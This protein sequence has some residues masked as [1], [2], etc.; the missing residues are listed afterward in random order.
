M[1]D[2]T[3]S[4][5]DKNVSMPDRIV[6]RTMHPG[7]APIVCELITRV[8]HACVAPSFT[9]EG[10]AAFLQYVGAHLLLARPPQGHVV[11]I[12]EDRGIIVGAV[13]MRD[14][15]HISLFFVDEAR[16]GEGIGRAL[17]ADAVERCRRVRPD[18]REIS[19][20]AS[21]NAVVAYE[22]LG[23]H[24]TAEEQVQEGMRFVPMVLPLEPDAT[25]DT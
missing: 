15:H 5:S 11:M 9:E 2:R 7:E 16:Q 20:H 8:F 24:S 3:V 25:A 6:I 1:P 19:V 13:E 12:A 10:G 14:Y 22:R 18:V 4:M 17:L 23:F 21:P